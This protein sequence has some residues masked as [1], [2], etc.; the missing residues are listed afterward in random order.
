[1]KCTVLVFIVFVKPVCIM[2]MAHIGQK[3]IKNMVKK[4]MK[5]IFAFAAKMNV[6]NMT[7]KQGNIKAH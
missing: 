6:F 4:Y 3:H 2:L 5:M 1:M 7:E